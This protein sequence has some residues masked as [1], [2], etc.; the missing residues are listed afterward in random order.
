[1]MNL[2]PEELIADAKRKAKLFFETLDANADEEGTLSA[3]A[4][5]LLDE[6]AAIMNG[7][8]TS[9]A[10]SLL[11]IH[12]REG[13]EA[14]GRALLGKLYQEMTGEAPSGPSTAPAP[15]PTTT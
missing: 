8:A 4:K 7:A 5:L 6:G 9:F 12:V 1:M 10:Q 15:S 14:E 13:R 3:L 2:S 11:A